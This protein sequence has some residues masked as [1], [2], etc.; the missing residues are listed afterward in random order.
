MES[1]SKD[2]SPAS[3]PQRSRKDRPLATG[4][5]ATREELCKEVRWYYD[6]TSMSIE[7]IGKRFGVSQKVAAGALEATPVA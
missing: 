4:T 1:E 3:A 5:C 6:N 7:A 2:V